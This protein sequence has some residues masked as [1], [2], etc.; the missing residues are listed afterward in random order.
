MGRG[1]RKGGLEMRSW[2]SAQIRYEEF[3][4]V[5][6]KYKKINEGYLVDADTFMEVESRIL[7]ELKELQELTVKAIKREKVN[8]VF[9]NS[10]QSE[11]AKWYKVRIKLDIYD[12]KTGREKGTT[13]VIMVSAESTQEAEKILHERMT[14]TLG[15]YEVLS[16][17]ETNYES[18][19]YH[20]A[21]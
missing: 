5:K 13:S 20:S 3:D 17:Q 11:E 16:I 4:T 18:I 6:G 2:F 14:G 12:E 15:V 21:E 1:S 7:G 9:D 10:S 19:W 8:E